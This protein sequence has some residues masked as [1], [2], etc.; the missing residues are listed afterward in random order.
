MITFKNRSKN[1]EVWNEEL[2]SEDITK[3]EKGTKNATKFCYFQLKPGENM[4]VKYVKVPGDE[5]YEYF[6]FKSSTAPSETEL[7]KKIEEI[8][9]KV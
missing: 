1:G 6:T 9:E 8:K 2:N 7:G 3:D 4:L 5:Q